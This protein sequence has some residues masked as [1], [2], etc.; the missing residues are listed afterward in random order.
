MRVLFLHNDYLQ[1]GGE[2]HSVAAEVSALRAHTDVTVSELAVANESLQHSRLAAVKAVVSSREAYE[3]VSDA[4]SHFDPDIVHV[5]NLFPRLGAG[6]LNALKSARVPYVRSLRNYRLRCIA[7]SCFFNGS[8]CVRCSA[9]GRGWPGVVRGC[10]RDSRTASAGAV[11]YAL[12]ESRATAAYPPQALIL[13]S[14]TMRGI[15]RDFIGNTPTFVK[16]NPVDRPPFDVPL[17]RAQR[18]VDVLFLGR[19]SAEKR[20]DLVAALA[21]QMR[22]NSF[23]IVGDGPLREMVREASSRLPNLSYVPGVNHSEALRQL[24]R[25]RV[26][27]VPSSWEEPFGRVAAEALAVGTP[28]VVADRGGLPD[29]VRGVDQSLIVQGDTEEAW[30][31]HVKAV[32]RADDSAYGGMVH[33]SL[34]QW[35]EAYSPFEN[36]KALQRIYEAALSFSKLRADD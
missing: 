6:A 9:A 14:N 17:G 22:D 33:A 4:I 10:Y 7:G 21:R 24:S 36:A 5:Q 31:G 19:L 16:P 2:R 35:K 18:N 28:A 29:I 25:A 15:L 3:Q 20:V 23:R 12:G 1:A 11:M 30:R 26:V 27:I 32:L 8:D 34:R 13:L